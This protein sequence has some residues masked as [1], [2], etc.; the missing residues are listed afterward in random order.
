MKYIKLLLTCF[1]LI[2]SNLIYAQSNQN[3]VSQLR[4]FNLN[5]NKTLY[6]INGL[7]FS[8]ES[9]SNKKDI[10]KK[11]TLINRSLR[12]EH[13]IKKQTKEFTFQDSLVIT[14][15][16]FYCKHNHENAVYY[17]YENPKKSTGF[18]SIGTYPKSINLKDIDSTVRLIINNNLPKFCKIKITDNTLNLDGIKIEIDS[19]SNGMGFTSKNGYNYL[20]SFFSSE[21]EANNYIIKF[22]KKR[23]A[24]YKG[25]YEGKFEIDVFKRSYR[26]FNFNRVHMVKSGKD[27]KPIPTYSNYVAS[28]FK[29]KNAYLTVTGIKGYIYDNDEL[30]FPN[31]FLNILEQ[32]YKIDEKNNL[33]TSSKK[34]KLTNQ[35]NG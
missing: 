18:I 29:F 1:Y 20:F 32:A 23:N 28:A 14:Q 27:S 8:K 26:A 17:K 35:L 10:R 22:L 6:S 11:N 9:Y 3:V 30:K 24:F 15:T 34:H 21:E 7:F 25:N 4:Y 2:L 16:Q 5:S 33:N 19:T 12:N 31:E 13:H